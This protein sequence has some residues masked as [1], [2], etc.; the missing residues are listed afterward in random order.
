[1]ASP[2][3]TQVFT[4]S[5]TRSITVRSTCPGARNTFGVRAA[6]TPPGV[7]VAMRSPGRSVVIW[8][9]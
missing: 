3:A 1:M 9:M 2:S 4:H 6:P 8:L 7:P 5:P